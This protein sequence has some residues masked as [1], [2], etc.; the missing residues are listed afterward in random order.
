MDINFFEIISLTFM[1]LLTLLEYYHISLNFIQQPEHYL[2]ECLLEVKYVWSQ[3]LV[4][5]S[6]KV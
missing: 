1:G 3:V 4:G 6:V 5:E 2:W